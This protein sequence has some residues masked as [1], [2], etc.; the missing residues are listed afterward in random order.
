MFNGEEEH[1]VE[2][3]RGAFKAY[4]PFSKEKLERLMHRLLNGPNEPLIGLFR[5]NASDIQVTI[6]F[7]TEFAKEFGSKYIIG[8]PEKYIM[9]WE[10]CSDETKKRIISNAS[11]YIPTNLTIGATEF[12]RFVGKIIDV[13][14]SSLLV[15]V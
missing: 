7:K 13:R 14:C 3:F 1:F 8:T 11:D 4:V 12:E 6:L 10:N 15:Y 5:S 2:F 9:G